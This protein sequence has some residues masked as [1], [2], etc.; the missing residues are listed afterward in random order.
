MD[1]ITNNLEDRKDAS[2]VLVEQQGLRLRTFGSGPYS[3][4]FAAGAV[5]AVMVPSFIKARAQGQLTTCKVNL[6]NEATA[7]EM[8]SVNNQGRYPA[9][10]GMVTP[11]YL[12]VIPNCPAAQSYTV[13]QSLDGFTLS[14]QGYNHRAIGI[15]PS[16]R[17]TPASRASSSADRSPGLVDPQ[18]ATQAGEVVEGT[19]R[20][21][22]RSATWPGARVPRSFSP[23]QRAGAPVALWMT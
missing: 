10:L 17:C 7:L 13:N 16:I 8:Y 4:T 11:N 19:P 23:S 22:T 20:T 2:L 21:S 3:L 18:R 14:C 6:K 9:K 1:P 12:K 15:P 5:A